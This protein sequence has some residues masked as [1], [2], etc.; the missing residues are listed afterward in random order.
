[1][2]TIYSKFLLLGLDFALF[3]AI[4]NAQTFKMGINVGLPQSGLRQVSTGTEEVIPKTAF[5]LGP[6]LGIRLSARFGVEMSAMYSALSYKQP[7]IRWGTLQKA[8]SAKDWDFPVLGQF[9]FRKSKG[10]EP[11]VGAGI[12]FRAI[13]GIRDSIGNPISRK[14]KGLTIASGSE[15]H[16]A[17]FI[18]RPELR[19]THWGAVTFGNGLDLALGLKRDQAQVSLGLIF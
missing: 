11:F 15:I 8:L 16:L 14:T 19:F 12:S 5:T 1:M 3:C 13:S 6:Q 17:R 10:H 7:L 4:S 9:F 2:K 18:I